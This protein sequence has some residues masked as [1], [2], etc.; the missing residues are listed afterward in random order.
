MED[1][2]LEGD[3]GL[4]VDRARED[5]VTDMGLGLATDDLSRQYSEW[6]AIATVVLASRGDNTLSEISKKM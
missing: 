2:R 4:L 6:S 5:Y 3:Q 1:H